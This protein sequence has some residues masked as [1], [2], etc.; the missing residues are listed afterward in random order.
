M[1]DSSI[2]IIQ[3][4]VGLYTVATRCHTCFA[5]TLKYT[6]DS[7]LTI[8]R[9]SLPVSL[10]LQY[11]P[12]PAQHC[13]VTC[14]GY[15][16]FLLVLYNLWSLFVG[17]TYLTVNQWSW[18]YL[19]LA[20]FE[21]EVGYNG[22]KLNSNSLLRNCTLRI[23]WRWRDSVSNWSWYWTSISKWLIGYSQSHWSIGENRVHMTTLNLWKIDWW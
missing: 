23:A 18:M 6:E 8:L 20:L 13:A 12:Q 9:H 5:V 17:S 4:T 1:S 16:Y 15:T 21:Q 14:T 19:S 11:Y 22:V 7:S 3:G 10:E 2:V